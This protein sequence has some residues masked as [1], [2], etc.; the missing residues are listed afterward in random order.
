MT[1]T[2]TSIAA[3]FAAAFLCLGG[4]GDRGTDNTGQTDNTGMS[5][6]APGDDYAKLRF[7]SHENQLRRS[8]AFPHRA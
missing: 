8:A 4:C 3:L 6:T 2:K 7:G 1:Y 5:D